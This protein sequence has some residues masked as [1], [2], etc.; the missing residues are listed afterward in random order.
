VARSS[1]VDLAK[2]AKPPKALRRV[3]L[4][5]DDG[6]LAM[7]LEEA[8]LRGGAGNVVI[9]SSMQQAMRELDKGDRPD[10]LIL[11]VHLADRDDGWALA[12]LVSLMGSRA[13][14]IA[15]STGSPEDIPAEVAAMGPV[16]EK[17]Y[18]P[19]MLVAALIGPTKP[20]LFAR[21]RR[22]RD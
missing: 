11:D 7:A 5:E 20:G 1:A 18:D 3:L 15:F 8:L 19:D 12:E 17:P 10:A 21:L 2:G 14:R 6:L 22:P 16:F 4:V 13:P 9:C